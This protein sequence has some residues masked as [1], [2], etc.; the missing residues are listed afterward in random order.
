MS[1]SPQHSPAAP[2]VEVRRQSRLWDAEPAA[3]EAVRTAI[4]ATAALTPTEGEVN[5]LLADDA[6]LREL[7]RRWRGVDRPTNVLSFPAARASGPLLGDIAIAYETVRGESIEQSK[8]FLDHL[9]HLAV[10]GFLHLLG[11]DH[12]TDSQA[13][14]MEGIERQALARLEIADPYS[15]RG[16]ASHPRNA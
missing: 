2:H 4:Q 7:N 1:W 8:P 13:D 9:A 6:A 16:Q 5:V 3:A 11:Y 12:A 14:A 10:H 15:E